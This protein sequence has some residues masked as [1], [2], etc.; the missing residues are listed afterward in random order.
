MKP[1]LT[2]SIRV[3]LTSALLVPVLTAIVHVY[4]LT[5]NGFHLFSSNRLLIREINSDIKLLLFNAVYD[6]LLCF[7]FYH[8]TLALS[9][10]G[11]ARRRLKLS[12]MFIGYALLVLLDITAF[13]MTRSLP[14]DLKRL[15][16][17]RLTHDV[18]CRAL[19]FMPFVWLYRLDL[20]YINLPLNPSEDEVNT[21]I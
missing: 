19:S 15:Y 9:K 13:L 8:V 1:A 2:Y 3:W 5:A 6:A 14:I 11:V 10:H 4:F 7:I 17:A 20:A 21:N 18:M 16:D 12:L